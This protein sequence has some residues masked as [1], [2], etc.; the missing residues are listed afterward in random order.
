MPNRLVHSPSLYLQ[1]HAHNPIDWWPWGDEALATAKAQDKPIFLSIGYSSCHWCTV[2]EGEAFSDPEVAHFLNQNFLPIKVDREER[3]DLDSIYMQALQMMVGQGGWPLNIFLDPQDL[4]PF[5]G[6][7]YFPGQ[8]RYGRPGFLQVLQVLRQSYDQ[9]RDKLRDI[10][11]EILGHLRHSTTT[12]GSMDLSEGLLLK[13][14]EYSTRIISPNFGGNSFPMMPYGQ[15]ALRLTRFGGER[16]EAAQKACMQ[17]GLDLA[18]GGI[19]DQVGGGFHRYTVDATWTVPHF[20][21][22]LYDNGQIMEYLANLWSQG[23][24]EPALQRAVA[25]TVAWL[26]REML[27]AQG[28]FYGS[29]DADNFAEPDAAEPE[30]GAFYVWAYDLLQAHLSDPELAALEA[31]FTVSRGGNFEGKTVLQRRRSGDLSDRCRSA[32]AQLFHRRYGVPETAIAPVTPVRNNLEAKAYGGAGRIPPVTDTKM[33][34]SWNSLM[35]SGLARAAVAFGEPEYYGLATQAAQFILDRQWHQGRLHR[36]YYGNRDYGN[37]D[38]GNQEGGVAVAAQGEDYAFLIKALLDVGQASLGVG[39]NHGS[40]VVTDWLEQA[41]RVQEEFDR[42]LWSEDLGGYYNTAQDASEHLLVRERNYGDTAIPSTNGVAAM[43]LV[44]LGL[45]SDRPAYGDRAGQVLQSFST[46]MNQSAP[47]CP[48]LF[49]ALDYYR[50]GTLL[51]LD[52][53]QVTAFAQGYWP[54][55]VFRPSLDLPPG[56]LGM[57]CEGVA[58]GEPM[59]TVPELQDQLHRSSTRSL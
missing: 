24:R 26:K 14:L 33:I 20:E 23:Q 25:G 5:Y 4:L 46:V 9:D 58:C 59:A 50:N 10:R 55:V 27:D 34:V 42:L 8:P 53:T 21:K 16:A 15:T 29:Q 47:S 3:P 30:E 19:F 7:T 49:Q 48:S 54:T 41:Q 2:M 57:V 35:I 51:S 44:R 40:G 22:M 45:V 39:G 6:G 1:K 38:Y 17:R 52:R 36:L 37:Q 12:Q 31:E 11:Q 18:L 43:N 13:G 28:Y 56:S 32:L